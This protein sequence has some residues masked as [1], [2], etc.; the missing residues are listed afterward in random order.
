MVVNIIINT[1][2]KEASLDKPK[3]IYPCR[4]FLWEQCM[5]TVFRFLEN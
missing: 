3:F 4:T 2:K 5:Y 1:Y